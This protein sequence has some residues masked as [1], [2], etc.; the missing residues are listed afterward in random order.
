MI[1]SYVGE[2]KVFERLFLDGKLEVELCPQ[3]T[4][5]E[6]LRAGGAGIPAFYTPTGYG[7]KRAEGKE[8]RAVERPLVRARG[9]DHR[10]L[11]ASSRRGRATAG[12]TS[13]I[14]RRRATSTRCAPPPGASPSPRSRSSSRSAQLDPDQIH[15]PG[16]YVQRIFQGTDYEKPIEQRT[17]RARSRSARAR[18]SDEQDGRRHDAARRRRRR[19]RQG[20]ARRARHHRRDPPHGL[21]PVL[22]LADGRGVRGARARGGRW[23]TPRRCSTAWPKSSS[24]RR[25]PKRACR[26]AT[27]T[28]AAPPS[29]RLRSCGRARWPGR[30]RL[31]LV[32]PL[33]GCA[34]LYARSFALGWSMAGASLALFVGRRR[35]RQPRLAG[36]RGRAQ[37]G[38][39]R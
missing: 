31:G 28:S 35:G 12:A 21:Q 8:T 15:T 29:C 30:W 27:T 11:R 13:S 6:R 23:P 17:V 16:I 37:G 1:S 2:N 22:R 32:G 34:L 25:W 3:G 39:H 4:L 38:R 9:G 19:G 20:A 14:A 18:V 10:R 5:A 33:P 36:H 7:T 26:P 24:G